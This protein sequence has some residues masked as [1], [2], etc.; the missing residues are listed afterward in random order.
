MTRIL[1]PLLAAVA[2]PTAVEAGYSSEIDLMTDETKIT[3]FHKSETQVLNS[4]GIEESAIITIRCNLKDKE[5][6]NFEVFINT[7][8]Y[9]ANNYEVGLRWN[10]GERIYMNWNKSADGTSFF[11][12]LPREFIT[13]LMDSDTLV[14]QWTPYNKIPQAVKFNLSELKKDIDNIKK[15]GCFNWL[16]IESEKIQL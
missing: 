1:L 15:E 10:K 2:L 4:I 8:T 7:P 11:T 3:V 14:F 9:N 6:T 13:K 12:Q 5:V 16:L